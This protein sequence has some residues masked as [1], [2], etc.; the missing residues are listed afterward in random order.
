MSH[1]NSSSSIIIRGGRVLGLIKSSN[2]GRDG[3]EFKETTG[4]TEMNIGNMDTDNTGVDADVVLTGTKIT[5]IMVKDPA[6][7]A[8]P[9]PNMRTTDAHNQLDKPAKIADDHD[10]AKNILI[11]KTLVSKPLRTHTHSSDHRSSSYVAQTLK[12]DGSVLI[13]D[14]S[15]CYV[16]P[17][18][19]DCHLHAYQHATPLGIDVDEFCLKRGV[20]TAVDAGSAG[21]KKF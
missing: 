19:I 2:C 13:F 14:A 20:T 12:K 9:P 1:N 11:E 8:I 17:G 3:P 21:E 5:G 10:A 4:T 18:L 15:G 6:M 16:V 7:E